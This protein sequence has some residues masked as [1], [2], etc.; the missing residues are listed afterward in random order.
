MPC[1]PEKNVT[2]LS[3][4][5]LQNSVIGSSLWQTLVLGGKRSGKGKKC[6]SGVSPEHFVPQFSFQ[7]INHCFGSNFP[8]VIG[9]FQASTVKLGALRSSW[10]AAKEKLWREWTDCSSWD[11]VLFS[12]F[13]FTFPACFARPLSEAGTLSESWRVCSLRGLGCKGPLAVRWSS[14][15]AGLSLQWSAIEEGSTP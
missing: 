11:R 6:W 15:A 4:E 1:P 2:T 9:P 5:S 14:L 7:T 3:E 13:F 8:L 10:W 12:F